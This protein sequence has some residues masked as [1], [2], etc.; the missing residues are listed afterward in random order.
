MSKKSASIRL[1]KNKTKKIYC[2]ICPRKQI[3]LFDAQA[4]NE[5]SLI[6]SKNEG[7]L[8]TIIKNGFLSQQEKF[9]IFTVFEDTT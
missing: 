3:S 7:S 1:Y 5:G 8:C 6:F 9:R 4:V 2:T